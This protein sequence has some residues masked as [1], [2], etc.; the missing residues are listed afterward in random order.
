MSFLENLV[1]YEDVNTLTLQKI[2]LYVSE[3]LML[4]PAYLRSHGHV[5]LK[6]RFGEA[7]CRCIAL[8]GHGEIGSVIDR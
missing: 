2:L 1:A 7:L 5:A 4:F 3:R 8:F 6:I